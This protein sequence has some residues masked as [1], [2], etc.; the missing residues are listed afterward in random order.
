MQSSKPNPSRSLFP[1]VSLNNFSQENYLDL[2]K[3]A[4]CLSLSEL[5]SRP[6][7]T[8]ALLFFEPSTRTR[9]SFE[10]ALKAEGYLTISIESG[11]GTSIEKGETLEDTLFNVAAMGVDL[12][13]VRTNESFPY[14]EVAEQVRQPILCG[15]WGRRAHPSQALLDALTMQDLGLDF[16]ELRVLIVGD[17][18]HSR[19]FSS[20]LELSQ[21]LG[22]QMAVC[23]PD[24]LRSP[25]VGL[26]HFENLAEGL[27]WANVVMGL[28]YQKE[29]HTEAHAF[30]EIKTKFG[31]NSQ[32][33]KALAPRSL[34]LHPGPVE[35]GLEMEREVLKDPR[36]RIWQQVE[37]GV[38]VR[39][40][41]VR[42]VSEL[43]RQQME[44]G[45]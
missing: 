43:N 13:V 38:R 14:L 39:R 9:L 6:Q 18:L 40:S 45:E 26:K 27:E 37:N 44:K 30:T 21:I 8:A 32:S 36:C 35:F 7:G 15:G 29:R 41:L 4:K 24:N 5:S 12:L 10:L 25:T 33:L 3:T 34:I 17:V 11:S 2:L 20:H 16:A 42:W 23:A 31:L 28:R 1:F 22:Y 19:V